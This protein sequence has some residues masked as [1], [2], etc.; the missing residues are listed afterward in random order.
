M[1]RILIIAAL[2]WINTLSQTTVSDRILS[3]R[4]GVL[5][6]H[7]ST[8]SVKWETAY[9]GSI[10]ILYSTDEGN[11]WKVISSE[12]NASAGQ[13]L[14]NTPDVNSSH[15]RIRIQSVKPGELD[16]L[17][18]TFIIN[19]INKYY[20][21]KWNGLIPQLQP[22]NTT[23]F[24]G[25]GDADLNGVLDNNDIKYIDYILT[26]SRGPNIRADVDGDM[27]ITSED[28]VRLQNAINGDTLS[29]WW[30]Y[31]QNKEE[32]LDWLKRM[33]KIDKTDEHEYIPG[34][35]ECSSFASQLFRSF[36][37]M[38]E[39]SP[40]YYSSQTIFNLPVYYVLIN[41]P[42]GVPH[43][44][45]AILMGEDP[46]DFSN[47][48]F[49]EPQNDEIV[50]LSKYS[51]G[52]ELF[53]M[54]I[55]FTYLIRF[56]KTGSDDWNMKFINN[57]MVLRKPGVL[58]DLDSKAAEWYPV[59]L[60]D[61][62]ILFER[63]ADDMS[64]DY[65]IHIS[66]VDSMV[67]ARPL[68][69]NGSRS[70]IVFS[71]TS[72]AGTH[73]IWQEVKETGTEY[74]YGS[75]VPGSREIQNIQNLG[76]LIPRSFAKI[77]VSIRNDRGYMFWL[78]N[79]TE[80]VGKIF[81][82]EFNS[83]TWST[84]GFID[85][86][87]ENASII[88]YEAGDDNDGNYHLFV[89]VKT[90]Y[91]NKL[92]ILSSNKN[93]NNTFNGD[94]V[95]GSE[96]Y[97]SNHYFFLSQRRGYPWDSVTDVG[98]YTYQDGKWNIVYSTFYG[99]PYQVVSTGDPAVPFYLIGAGKAESE[100]FLQAASVINSYITNNRLFVD[101]PI[102]TSPALSAVHINNE[103]LIAWKDDLSARIK[104]TT[105]KAE[106]VSVEES[107]HGY[108]FQL[109]QNY[110]NPF[111]AETKIDY[112]VKEECGVK[113]EIF[114]LLGSISKTILDEYQGAGEYSVTFN[115]SGLP[116]GIYFYRLSSGNRIITKKMLLL[117]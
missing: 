28:R 111:N 93:W 76:F 78:N 109:S 87:R 19:D 75:I 14:W 74:F 46:R 1:G 59:L 85:I 61:G 44:L 15:C 16:L 33:L 21:A 8:V 36:A 34:K 32:K 52:T 113:I 71:R 10:K 40:A 86:G 2:C 64:R 55:S 97:F 112:S 69:Q 49:I 82:S 43:N 90:T 3:P 13:F 5:L 66:P 96:I 35:Y 84:P 23:D 107:G 9:Q 77:I 31:Y 20:S 98:M 103:I 92:L 24:Y 7:L 57:S 108:S 115:G 4:E 94:F 17:S 99:I 72:E 68:F 37:G 41:P 89:T 50:T 26:G 6:Q 117:K 11:T 79:V 91:W 27:L 48:I 29:S 30:N 80:D 62:R 51:A 70:H 65:K 25:S 88:D 45:N 101:L 22:F 100:Y 67:T 47:W 54:S 114:D 56:D 38:N 63:A 83:G 73:L 95:T 12:T 39:Y 18:S 81:Y 53:I 60:S 102:T 105:Y 104:H 110:P 116:S 42:S 58:P 106:A